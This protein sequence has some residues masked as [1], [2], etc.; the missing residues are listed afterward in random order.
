MEIIASSQYLNIGLES[1]PPW[2]GYRRVGVLPCEF[3][4]LQ[5]TA[6]ARSMFGLLWRKGFVCLPKVAW[7]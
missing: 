5:G 3:P 1:T 7:Y 4:N 6:E 2:G